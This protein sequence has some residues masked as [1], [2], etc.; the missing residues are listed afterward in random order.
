[1]N[2][3]KLFVNLGLIIL[4]LGISYFTMQYLSS[5][6]PTPESRPREEAKLFVRAQQVLYGSNWAVISAT[7]RLSSQE[8]VDLS[9]EVQGQILPGRVALKSGTNFKEGN[10]LL[11]I[12]DEEAK[13]N[14]KAS[15]SRFMNGIASILPDI[16]IDFPDSYDKYEAFFNSIEITKPL[17]DL[18]NLDSDK[19]KVFLASRNILNDYFSIK[20]AE[21]RLEKHKLYAPFDGT[22]TNVFMEVGSVANM[23]SRIASMI[24]T[25]KLELSVPVETQDIYWIN[26]GDKVEVSTQDETHSWEGVVARKSGF[27]DPG[28][29]SITVYVNLKPSPG[30]QLYQGQYLKATFSRI[31]IENSFEIPRNAVFNKDKV[32]IVEDSILQIREIKVHKLTPTTVILSGLDTGDW[33]VTEPLINVS[34]GS[35][36]EILK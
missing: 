3:R 9:S 30:N 2:W 17:P 35:F 24:R 27:V 5:L 33:V 4:V 23:G 29:Q 11:R 36:A 34:E 31:N 13:N 26:I 22:F 1:M 21:V 7:G 28:T 10:L 15:K 12:F 14:L 20:S 25:D 6:K 32:F 18:P 19:E 16:R 8:E